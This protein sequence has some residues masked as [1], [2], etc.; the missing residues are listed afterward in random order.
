[1]V[2]DGLSLAAKVLKISEAHP[3][4]AGRVAAHPS[5]PD[6]P[7][8]VKQQWRVVGQGARSANGVADGRDRQHGRRQDVHKALQV[9]QL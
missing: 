7:G 5:A 1:M 6:Q 2:N 4:Y 9:G 3:V 8:Y